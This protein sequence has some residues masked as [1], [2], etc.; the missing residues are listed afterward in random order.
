[1]RA[2]SH[3]SALFPSRCLP[4]TADMTSLRSAL[5]PQHLRNVFYRMGLSDQD[6]V[7]LSGAH[8]LGRG[9]RSCWGRD[10]SV[11]QARAQREQR[12]SPRWRAPHLPR[13]FL[14]ACSPP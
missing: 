1:M 6:I 14:P 13:L 12:P 7:A 9:E 3:G 11:A 4:P 8:T 5:R 2:G 10:V